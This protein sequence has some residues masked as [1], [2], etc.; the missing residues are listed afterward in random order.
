MNKSLIFFGNE[1]LASGCTTN[2][3]VLNSLIDADFNVKLIVIN[4][5]PI[6]SRS[7]KEP[8][9]IQFAKLHSIPILIP[10]NN[11]ELKESILSLNVDF[12]V[13][14]AYGKIIPESI[15]NLFKFGI[16][17]LHPSL[18]PKYRGP[19]PIEAAILNG[20][21]ATGVTIMSLAK[22]MDDGPIYSQVKL[23]VDM[24]FSKQELMNK[25][26]NLGAAELIRILSLILEEGLTPQQQIGDPAICSLIKKE[27]QII[28][29]ATQTK[30]QI[31]RHLKAYMGWPGSKL[32]IKLKGGEIL[33]LLLEELQFAMETD[34]IN[35]NKTDNLIFTKNKLFI[36][37][38]DGLLEVIKLRP[39]SKKSMLAKEFINGYRSSLT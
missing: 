16:I 19:T 17:N 24:D 15:I 38:Q 20:D 2:L 30:D 25:L 8:A 13:L 34:L 31:L 37:A 18:L 28:S 32:L 9:V 4:Q 36:N 27:D 33:T 12:A 22:G 10:E 7:Q 14:A 5:K 23:N 6:K 21:P 26:G 3:P 1:V 35:T 11:A 39:A 29:P